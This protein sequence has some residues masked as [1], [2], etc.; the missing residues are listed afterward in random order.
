MEGFSKK[1]LIWGLFFTMIT[2]ALLAIK[3]DNEQMFNEQGDRIVVTELQTSPCFVVSIKSP[4]VDGY[5][6]MQ[7]GFGNTK[8]PKKSLS[9]LFK[10]A[11]IKTPLR[12]LREFRF[13]HG[14]VAKES[15]KTTLTVNGHTFTVGEE[16]KA[17]DIFALG[18][19]V[20]VT[21]VSKGKGFQ[22]VVRRHN[23]KGGPATHGQ[24]DRE[25]APGS[26][27]QSATPG[28]VFKGKRMAGRMGSDTITVKNLT[29]IEAGNGLLKISGLVPGAKGTLIKIVSNAPIPEKVVEETKEEVK[30]VK[31]ETAKV[32]E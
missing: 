4:D 29:V 6:S 30:E 1:P 31:E 32:E 3:G 10:N 15:K 12:F 26:I 14:E 22:G 13:D 27:G 28:R 2:K 7:I 25:R 24:S 5:T 11:G 21:G 8:N 20:T 16:L 18:D 17:E 19:M 9:G 23:F